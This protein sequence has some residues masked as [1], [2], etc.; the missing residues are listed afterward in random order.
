[1]LAMRVK[2]PLVGSSIRWI[3]SIDNGGIGNGS[4]SGGRNAEMKSVIDA[5]WRNK[6]SSLESSLGETTNSLQTLPRY[7]LLKSKEEIIREVL[8]QRENRASKPYDG[9]LVQYKKARNVFSF[10]KEG[11]MNVWRVHR[12]LGKN[13]YNGQRYLIDYYSRTG[14]D[15]GNGNGKYVV[16]RSDYAQIVEDVAVRVQ[17]MRTEYMNGS[18]TLAKLLDSDETEIKLSRREFVELG[19]DAVNWRKLPIFGLLFLILE[20]MSLP[21]LYVFPGMIPST[22]VL[23]GRLEKRYLAHRNASLKRL[24]AIR[25]TNIEEAAKYVQQVAMGTVSVYSVPRGEIAYVGGVFGCGTSI[26][27]VAFHVRRL[28][29]DDFLLLRARDVLSLPEAVHGLCERGFVEALSGSGKLA[30]AEAQELLRKWLS[31]R[32]VK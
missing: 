25:G 11:I 7:D 5:L 18:R 2:R 15:N 1:M 20:E 19:R 10:F 17:L 27:E 30:E 8:S 23:P 6:E 29:A 24:S 28:S 3:S 9:L 4:G 31:A 12:E 22:C 14:N 21:L 32:F 13:I 16:R 26:R